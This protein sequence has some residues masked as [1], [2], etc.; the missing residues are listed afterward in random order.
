MSGIDSIAS[1]ITWDSANE[2]IKDALEE[3][4]TEGYL[5]AYV[6]GEYIDAAL[7]AINGNSLGVSGLI[8]EASEMAV[9]FGALSL[10]FAFYRRRK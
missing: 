4:I 6:N 8:P 9:I 3:A 5:Q 7:F 1:I 10:A 2:T